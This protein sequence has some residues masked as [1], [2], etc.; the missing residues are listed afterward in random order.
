MSN[1]DK[2]VNE[3]ELLLLA[4]KVVYRYAHT[5]PR[6]EQEDVKMNMVEKYLNEESKICRNFNG[7]SKTTTY[8]MAILNRMCCGIIRKEI[9][10]WNNA[11]EDHLSYE[12]NGGS[13]EETATQLLINDEIKY[14][15]KVIILINDNYKTVVFLAFYF[16]LQTKIFFLKIYD[17]NYKKHNLLKL[18]STKTPL[19]KGQIFEQLAKTTNIVEKNNIKGDAVRMWLNKQQET[20]LTRLNGPY[21]RASYNKESFTILFEYYYEKY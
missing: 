8:V 20:I 14:L 10:H 16:A 1:S 13:A 4:Q 21:N 17:K 9:K 15:K 11:G 18:L 2:L 7:N 3:K 12:N 5:I 19:S 6:T